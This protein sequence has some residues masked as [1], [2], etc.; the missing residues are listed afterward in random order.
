MSI[1]S[2][3][4]VG[5]AV[6]MSRG[7]NPQV[8]SE[9]RPRIGRLTRPSSSSLLFGTQGGSA[10]SVLA[11]PYIDLSRMSR[12]TLST[13]SESQN[14]AD[15]LRRVQGG[16]HVPFPKRASLYSDHLSWQKGR[17]REEHKIPGKSRSKERTWEHMLQVYR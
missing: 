2:P 7:H 15:I 4:W 17:K 3:A 10:A 6:K 14:D 5:Q 13:Y 8:C 12:R 1:P 16:S 11:P 9:S